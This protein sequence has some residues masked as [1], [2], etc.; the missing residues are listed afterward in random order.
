MS[1]RVEGGTLFILVTAQATLD[2]GPVHLQVSAIEGP[3]P[4]TWR[5]TLGAGRIARAQYGRIA[6]MADH[7]AVLR[8]AA[9]VCA[10]G[11]EPG[12]VERGLL[13]QFAAGDMPAIAPWAPTAPPVAGV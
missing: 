9:G 4:G 1:T 3:T 5:F 6:G 13:E 12:T 8:Y 10:A 7:M 2:A 11:Y